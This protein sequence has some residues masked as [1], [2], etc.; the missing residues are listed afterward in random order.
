MIAPGLDKLF[1]RPP[2][3]V[4]TTTTTTTTPTT[5]TTTTTTTTAIIPGLD[6]LLEDRVA[7]D[8]EAE[9]GNEHP[10]LTHPRTHT[11]SHTH[12]HIRTRTHARTHART[13]PKAGMNTP[14]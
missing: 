9:G 8:R 4:T 11:P 6:D 7:H 5:T 13:R 3:G 2:E 12:T 1:G 14:S 10:R